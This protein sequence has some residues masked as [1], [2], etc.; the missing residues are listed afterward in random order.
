M[1]VLEVSCKTGTD[2]TLFRRRVDT[3]KDQICLLDAFV[4]VSREEK[5]AS[6]GLTDD[7][8]QSRLV[9]GNIVVFTVPCI[10]ALL[11][12]VD[13]GDLDMGALERYDR[14]CWPTYA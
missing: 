5:I 13:D 12:Q 14:T 10:D 3:D 1:N 2:T 11:I 8:H 6:S 7:I 4:H 9:N